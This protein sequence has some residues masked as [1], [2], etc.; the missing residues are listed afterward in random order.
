MKRYALALLCWFASAESAT[1]Q[2][3]VGSAVTPDNSSI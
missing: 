2:D 3:V 1:A